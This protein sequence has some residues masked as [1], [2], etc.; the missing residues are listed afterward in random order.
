MP[1]ANAWSPEQYERFRSEREQPFHD[2]VALIRPHSRPGERMTIVDLGCGTGALTRQLHD[3]FHALETVGVDSSPAMLATARERA[4]DGARDLHFAQGD[5]TAFAPETPFDLV[6][7]NAA[8]HWLPDH[9]RLFASLTSA[10]APH[11]QLAVQMPANDD[12]PAWR[13]AAIL[14]REEPFTSAMDG[15]FRQSPVLPPEHYALLLRDLGYAQQQVRLQVYLHELPDRDAVIEWV[16]GA[17][18]TAYQE[19]MPVDLFA[20]FLIEYGRR[21]RQALPDTR[22]YLFPFKRLLLWAR[23]P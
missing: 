17:L 11:G 18:L 9:P 16:R 15:W 4:T 22:P 20:E 7:S 6:F 23:K 5:I 13:L 10:V 1:A 21:L 2:L 14:A 8:L 3:R 19:R 12:H